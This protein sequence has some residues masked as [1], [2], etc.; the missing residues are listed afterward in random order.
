MSEIRSGNL[1]I[2]AKED[3]VEFEIIGKEFACA[4]IASSEVPELLGFF[5]SYLRAQSNR[6]TGFRINLAQLKPNLSNRLCVTVATGEGQLSATPIDLGLTGICVASNHHLGRCGAKVDI[7]MSYDQHHA[8][9]PAVVVRQDGAV[10]HTAFHFV[11][12]IKDGEP[13]P[14]PE[15]EFIFRK[16]EALWLDQSLQL[17]WS[18][19]AML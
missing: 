18:A 19:E 3:S 5:K 2:R 17:E 6:R 4:D 12:S 11:G 13:E 14:S 9:L 1:L 8:V 15:L 7:I 10:A 16:L